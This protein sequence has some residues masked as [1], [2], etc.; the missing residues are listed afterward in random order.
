MS[1]TQGQASP[2][3]EP[4]GSSPSAPST[5]V[6]FVWHRLSPGRRWVFSKHLIDTEWLRNTTG[7]VGGLS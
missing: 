1:G 5:F 3:T 7:G 6:T 4:P 2:G